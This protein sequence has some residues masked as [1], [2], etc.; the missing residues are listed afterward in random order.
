MRTAY[1]T[2]PNLRRRATSR[3]RASSV[4]LGGTDVTSVST[5]SA[6]RPWPRN[7][8]VS[9]LPPAPVSSPVSRTW[10]SASSRSWVRATNGT[11]SIRKSRSQP[12][13]R[14][15]YAEPVE[16]FDDH[17][18]FYASPERARLTAFLDGAGERR[19]VRDVCPLEGEDVAAQIDAVVA[20]VEARGAG[21]YAVDVTAADIRAAG[22]HV[23]KVVSPEL[24]ALDVAHDA[25]FLGGRRLYHAAFEAGLREEPLPKDELNPHPHPFP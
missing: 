17:I 4:V 5:R 18:R 24:C 23:A 25:R 3:R 16:T 20:R 13:V 14:Q 2:R 6:K 21:V 12:L 19:D 15:S 8:K 9:W 7:A 10:T 11:C 22:L 1:G